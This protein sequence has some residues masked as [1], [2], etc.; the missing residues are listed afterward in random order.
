VIDKWE[1]MGLLLDAC[2]SFG[3]EWQAFQQEWADEWDDPPLYVVLADFARHLIGFVERGQF[4]RLSAALAAVERL[5]LEGDEFVRNAAVSGLL[6]ALDNGNLHTT[7]QPADLYPYL[8]P[9][10]RRWWDEYSD[11]PPS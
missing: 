6:D 7:T 1:M 5:H 11:S 3:L 10:S 4:D 8:G 9:E 2:P